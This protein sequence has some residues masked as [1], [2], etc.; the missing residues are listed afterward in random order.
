[1]PRLLVVVFFA[2]A[3]VLSMTT[4]AGAGSTTDGPTIHV[5]G[6]AGLNLE[7]HFTDT[8]GKEIVFSV[9]GDTA[10]NIIHKDL[11]TGDH[12]D[13]ANVYIGGTPDVDGPVTGGLLIDEVTQLS[14]NNGQVD[15]QRRLGTNNDISD[16]TNEV[17]SNFTANNTLNF[18]YYYDLDESLAAL[19]LTATKSVEG[20]GATMVT[21]QFNFEILNGNDEVIATG[22]NTADG[23][24]TFSTVTFPAPAPDLSYTTDDFTVKEVAGTDTGWAYDTSEFSGNVIVSYEKTGAKIMQVATPNGDLAGTISFTNTYTPEES[25]PTTGTP[26]PRHKKRTKKAPVK[27][28]RHKKK[29]P[30]QSS[31]HKKKTPVAPTKHEKKHSSRKPGSNDKPRTPKK[32]ESKHQEP[33][34]DPSKK[35]A[36]KKDDSST[37]TSGS[38]NPTGGDTG[39]NTGGDNTGGDTGGNTNTNTNTNTNH[40]TATVTVIVPKLPAAGLPKTDDPLSIATYTAALLVVTGIVT[41]SAAVALSLKRRRA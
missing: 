35:R 15:A 31:K 12:F 37:D 24:I 9:A 2:I 34:V 38:A 32:K 22:T 11:V 6:G 10:G 29:V 20:E 26:T 36:C 40:T 4:T 17:V 39:D 41:A 14:R 27:P 23:A 19:K 21:G 1:M 18:F 33:K 8:E 5:N 13:F 28:S 25:T 16:S 30:T 7:F 3:L